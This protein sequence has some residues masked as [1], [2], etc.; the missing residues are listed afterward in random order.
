MVFEVG[1][2]SATLSIGGERFTSEVANRID[3]FD[4]RFEKTFQLNAKVKMYCR[5]INIFGWLEL[6]T[7]CR[8]LVILK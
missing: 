7:F 5:L 4:Q 2:F 8:D 1:M 3:R 6:V